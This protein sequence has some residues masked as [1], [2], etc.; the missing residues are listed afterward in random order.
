VLV[1]GRIDIESVAVGGVSAH[2]VLLERSGRD[3]EVEVM[4][5]SRSLLSLRV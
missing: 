5:G 3:W 2:E 1:V 4:V